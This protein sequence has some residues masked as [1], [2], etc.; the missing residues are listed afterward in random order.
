LN[1]DATYVNA[2]F[3]HGCPA[4]SPGHQ[5][6]LYGLVYSCGYGD[7]ARNRK[8]VFFKEEGVVS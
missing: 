8:S 1:L 3:N 7:R 5:G 2:A 6:T 4:R